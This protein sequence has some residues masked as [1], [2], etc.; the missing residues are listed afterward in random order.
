MLLYIVDLDHAIDRLLAGKTSWG[1]AH[2]LSWHLSRFP[3]RLMY[4]T[5][6]DVHSWVR[7]LAPSI[8]PKI[9]KLGFPAI[10]RASTHTS[11]THTT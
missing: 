5:A 8:L 10:S 9:T 2:G 1:P 11:A 4:E 6:G 3:S 7:W